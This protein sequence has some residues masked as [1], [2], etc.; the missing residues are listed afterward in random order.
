MKKAII[1]TKEKCSYCDKA[2][3]LFKKHDIAYDEYI[4]GKTVT[5]EDLL[6]KVPT[7]KSVPQIFINNEHIG[8]Y[9]ELVKYMEKQNAI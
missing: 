3:D 6:K 4:I 9:D 5:K 2:K 7:A 1:W 8:G